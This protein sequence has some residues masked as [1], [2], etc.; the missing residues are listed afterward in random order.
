[1]RVTRD[2]AAPTDSSAVE[3]ADRL[4][5][6]DAVELDLPLARLGSR[7][8]ARLLDLIVQ[9]I[10]LFTVAPLIAMVLGAVLGLDLAI[11]SVIRVVIQVLVFIAYPVALETLTRGRTLG[12]LAMGLR[13]VRDDGGA[14]RFRQAFT[15]GLVGMAAEWPGLLPPLTWVASLWCMLGSPQSKRFGDIAAGTIVIHERTPV[16]WGW[17]PVTPPHLAAWAAT[18]DLTALDDRLALDIR[19]FLVRYRFLTDKARARVGADLTL[20]VIGCVTPRP[21]TGTTGRDFLVAVLAERHRR[22]VARIAAARA[23]T[24]A[25]WPELARATGVQVPS[26]AP[27]RPAVSWQ[28]PAA[29]VVSAAPAPLPSE[30]PPA[31]GQGPAAVRAPIRPAALEQR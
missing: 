29:P 1:M 30:G 22:S 9:A 18:L 10:L 28:F 12:K 5:I 25:V 14:I 2:L 16:V 31:G 11:G 19:Q 6:G 20:E 15:R 21:P 17:I 4:V 26:Q 7:G 23:S 24:A 13:V 3:S 27:V 8:L